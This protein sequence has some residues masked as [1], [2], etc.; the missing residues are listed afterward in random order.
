MQSFMQ[1]SIYDLLTIRVVLRVQDQ[2]TY[3]TEDEVSQAVVA[4]LEKDLQDYY[5]AMNSLMAQQNQAIVT[6]TAIAGASIVVM[7]LVTVIVVVEVR[8]MRRVSLG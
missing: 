5:S 7:V 1:Q 3:P 4:S 2:P 6:A 8:R